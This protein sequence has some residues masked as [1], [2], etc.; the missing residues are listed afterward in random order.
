MNEGNRIRW[1]LIVLMM[2]YIIAAIWLEP[3]P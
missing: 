1:A 2:A 3:L